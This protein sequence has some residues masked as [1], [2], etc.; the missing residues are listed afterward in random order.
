MQIW[1]CLVIFSHSDK[2]EIC[3]NTCKHLPAALG[4]TIGGYH[5]V[6]HVEHDSRV[7]GVPLVFVTN[8]YWNGAIFPSWKLKKVLNAKIN[9]S[10]LS[11][12]IFKEDALLNDIK[13]KKSKEWL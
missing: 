7:V 8:K 1:N 11:S 5:Q 3:M 13:A 4:T 9:I 10:K 2:Y 12:F 6:I